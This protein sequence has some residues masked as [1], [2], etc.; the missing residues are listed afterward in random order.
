MNNPTP[1][2]PP[3]PKKVSTNNIVIGQK[4]TSAK[5]RRAKE[6]RRQMTPE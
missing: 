1:P 2:P 5:V 6:L 4:V 3:I